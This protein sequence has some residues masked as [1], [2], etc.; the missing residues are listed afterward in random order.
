M[1]EIER[2]NSNEIS[3]SIWLLLV[4]LLINFYIWLKELSTIYS[5]LFFPIIFPQMI[6]PRN[7]TQHYLINKVL[8]IGYF[9]T[10][11]QFFELRDIAYNFFHSC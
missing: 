8:L 11:S 9:F 6:L 10:I 4:L 7:F 3:H 2:I 1:I 5:T